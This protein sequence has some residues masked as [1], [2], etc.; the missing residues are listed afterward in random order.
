M[1]RQEHVMAVPNK[2]YKLRKTGILYFYPSLS[3]FVQRD[4]GLLAER[5]EVRAF[6]L[7]LP[8][9]AALPGR[10]F[11]QLLFILRH[12]RGA[13]AFICHFAGYASLLPVLLGR[14]FGVRCYVVVAGTDA[15]CFPAIG[16]GNYTRRLLGF[17]T[18]V[19]L[20][21][22]GGI[23]PVHHSLIRQAYTYHE[24][25]SPVQGFAVFAPG[26]GKVPVLSIPYGYDAQV[27]RPNSAIQRNPG[28][29]V[30]AGDLSVP[31]LW[32]RKGFDL[33]VAL[34]RK[35]PELSFTLVGWDGKARTDLPENVRL[36]PFLSQQDLIDE[37]SAHEYYFQLS[38]MEGFPNALAE[39]M[40]CGCIPIGSAVSAIPDMIGNTGYLLFRCDAGELDSLV[41]R[42]LADPRRGELPALARRAIAGR[43]TPERRRKALEAVIGYGIAGAAARG[44]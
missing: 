26:S 12:G 17:V 44:F 19:S 5:F 1:N 32:R 28:T 2:D 22:A 18:R 24:A 27:F 13:A 21:H 31:T 35:R 41:N 43:F 30:S 11:A 40:L 38:M 33:I 20:R 7:D 25:G 9:K 23:L 42:A 6:G 3:S 15:A 37:L 34:A 14:L 39:A 29:F 8:G 16:Y 36:R 10:L 4:I